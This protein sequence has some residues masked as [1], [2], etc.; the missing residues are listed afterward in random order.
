LL[1][2]STRSAY[3][4]SAGCSLPPCAATDHITVPPGHQSHVLVAWGDPLFPYVPPFELD[5]LTPAS[6]Q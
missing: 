5:K 4:T 6:Q 1:L 3:A 2:A